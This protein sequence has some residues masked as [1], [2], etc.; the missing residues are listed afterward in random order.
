VKTLR[1]KYPPQVHNDGRF[2]IRHGK[3]EKEKKE[4]REKKFIEKV[5]L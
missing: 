2:H 1:I 4:K 5:F 3:R